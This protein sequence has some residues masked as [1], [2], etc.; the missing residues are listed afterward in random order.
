MT[1]PLHYNQI[2]VHSGDLHPHL[3]VQNC[4]MNACMMSW[5]VFKLNVSFS[6]N[7]PSPETTPAPEAA[8]L[9]SPSEP[10]HP[11]YPSTYRPSEKREVSQVAG[12]TLSMDRSPSQPPFPQP[13]IPDPPPSAERGRFYL[14]VGPAQGSAHLPQSRFA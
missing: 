1:L 6:R 12:P 10:L 14:V 7:V 8:P 11:Q 3:L 4:E 13:V 5:R 9:P 2:R